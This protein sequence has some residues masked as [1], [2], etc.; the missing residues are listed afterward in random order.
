MTKLITLTKKSRRLYILVSHLSFFQRVVFLQSLRSFP[1]LRLS[2]GFPFLF[3]SLSLNPW[4]FLNL[5]YSRFLS[6]LHL[7][8][9]PSSAI[10]DGLVGFVLFEFWVC[11]VFEN[12][13]WV[14]SFFLQSY[15]IYLL[16]LRRVSDC[17]IYHS[18][19]CFII[20]TFFS[21]SYLCV[22]FLLIFFVSV[23]VWP[24][25]LCFDFGLVL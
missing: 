11:S 2:L 3:T 24:M 7:F 14:W 23:C 1:L 21:W 18:W 25:H 5:I 10:S 9:L 6:S 15:K 19:Y 20:L 17:R 22:L 4:I 8:D 13:T 12:Q 16:L